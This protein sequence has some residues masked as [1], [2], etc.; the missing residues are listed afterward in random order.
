MAAFDKE[1][2]VTMSDNTER[3]SFRLTA[4]QADAI[5]DIMMRFSYKTR[6]QVIRAAIENLI[7]ES[8]EEWNTKKIIFHVPKINVLKI[9]NA[10][11]DGFAISREDLLNKALDK[12]LENIELT[13]KGEWEKYQEARTEFKANID[14]RARIT[15]S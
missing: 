4:T 2:L 12:F 6:S 15:K 8:R 1:V 13:I 7:N 10:V 3:V 14:H 9:D 5:D 11:E